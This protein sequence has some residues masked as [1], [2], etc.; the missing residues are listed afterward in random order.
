MQVDGAGLE[1]LKADGALAEIVVADEFE[2][3]LADVDRQILGPIIRDPFIGNIAPLL[4]GADLVGARSERLVH[5]GA[6]EGMSRVIGGRK[7]GL[8]GDIEDGIAAKSRTQ[9]DQHHV[10]RLGLGLIEIAQQLADDRMGFFAQGVQREDHILGGERR[11]VVKARLA[12]QVEPILALVARNFDRL[13]NETIKALS[14]SRLPAIRLSLISERPMAGLPDRIK[15]LS[16][17]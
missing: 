3:I 11:M 14:S 5:A 8:A 15:P 2:I 9:G 17:S 16:E 6:L 10:V 4:Q 7:Y 1:R 12:A 13:S